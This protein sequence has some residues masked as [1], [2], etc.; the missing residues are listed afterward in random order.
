VDSQQSDAAGLLV[1]DIP[2]ASTTEAA[3]VGGDGLL[4]I[5]RW[6]ED[7]GI[8]AATSQQRLGVD[9]GPRPA[10]MKHSSATG[11]DLVSNGLLGA[12]VIR[13]AAGE[14]FVP[15]THPGDHLLIVIGGHGTI[16]YDGR[17]YPTAAGEIYMIEGGMPHAVGAVTDHVILAVGAPHRPVG[18]VERMTPVEYDA[19]EVD[20]GK[21][22]CLIC[23]V[24]VTSSERLHA[25]GCT[26][27]P[28]P[29]C[30]QLPE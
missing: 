20:I 26:H 3:I 23:G 11:E 25:R 2:A 21:L 16:T 7:G 6:A 13:L 27:C 15:H 29:A 24:G 10:S 18:S 9:C 4:R 5:V 30:I 22:E 1:P 14:G 28:C 19:I 8:D 17:I 12:D